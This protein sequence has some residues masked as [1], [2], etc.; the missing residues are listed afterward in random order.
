MVCPTCGYASLAKT[1]KYVKEPLIPTFREKVST[2]YKAK[3]YP[4][5]YTYDDAIEQ[6]KLALYGGMIL[7]ISNCEKAYICLKLAWLYRGK[8]DKPGDIEPEVISEAK[9]YEMTFLAQ[10]YEGFKRAIDKENFPQ[11][12]IDALT[13]NYIIGELARRLGFLDEAFEVMRKLS[14]SNKITHRLKLRVTAAK[15]KIVEQVGEKKESIEQ[16]NKKTS[17][18]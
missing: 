12:G 17:E 10:A 1:F 11:L 5:I 18:S 2:K 15:E 16:A 4:T 3:A 14:I 13:V 6:Y 9:E 7:N 8:Q